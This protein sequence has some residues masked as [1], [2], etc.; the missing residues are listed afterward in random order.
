MHSKVEL[1]LNVPSKQSEKNYHHHHHH[2]QQQ[3]QRGDACILNI[4]CNMSAVLPHRIK[5]EDYL[6]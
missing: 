5:K 2:Q 3:Q 1:F 4:F 6:S